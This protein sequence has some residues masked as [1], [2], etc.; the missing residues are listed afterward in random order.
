MQNYDLLPG[1][2]EKAMK[3]KHNEGFTLVELLVSI[4]ILAAIVIPTCTSLV[5][6]YR[7]N[8]KSE[9]MLQAQLAVSSAVEKLMAEGIDAKRAQDIIAKRQSETEAVYDFAWDSVNNKF[10]ETDDYPDVTITIDEANS[11]NDYYTLVVKD[12]D[13]LVIVTTCIR[14][15]K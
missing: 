3:R 11:N 6:S 8:A 15:A 7:M 1:K 10:S 9:E 4:V 13:D 5:L 2:E 12:N 14:V